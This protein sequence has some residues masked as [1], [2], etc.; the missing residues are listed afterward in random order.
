MCVQVSEECCNRILAAE[1]PLQ[2]WPSF[3]ALTTWPAI[4]IRAMLCLCVQ[5]SEECSNCILAIEYEYAHNHSFIRNSLVCCAATSHVCVQVSEE[6]S[7]RILA[8]EYEYAQKK[9]GALQER[10]KVLRTI[11]QFWK[12]VSD[13]CAC[14]TEGGGGGAGLGEVRCC[15]RGRGKVCF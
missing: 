10:S 8:I 2:R 15:I 6:C 12:K 7:N 5:V 1:T 14:E 3:H 9:R 4:T 13:M 11:P